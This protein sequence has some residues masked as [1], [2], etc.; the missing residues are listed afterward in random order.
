M[1]IHRPTKAKHVLLDRRSNVVLI[2]RFAHLVNT[3]VNACHQLTNASVAVAATGFPFSVESSTALEEK[4]ISV[5]F[6]ASHKKAYVSSKMAELESAGPHDQ[7]MECMNLNQPIARKI[8][9]AVSMPTQTHQLLCIHSKRPTQWMNGREK[10]L[11]PILG[12]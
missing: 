10:I 11:A 12:M 1:I 4:A 6:V 2:C 7:P 3:S 5:S 9:Y 8:R